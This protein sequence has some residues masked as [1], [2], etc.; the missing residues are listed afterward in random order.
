MHQW[1]RDS[2]LGKKIATAANAVH[3]V[4]R[5]ERCLEYGSIVE[6]AHA[7]AESLIHIS[8]LNGRVVAQD[9]WHPQKTTAEFEIELLKR[10]AAKHNM[11]L[12]AE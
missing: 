7:D 10:L 12:T 5:D 3:A 11:K 6:V 4:R 2:F 8:S 9:Y 1:E